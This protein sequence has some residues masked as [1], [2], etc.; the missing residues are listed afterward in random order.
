MAEIGFQ[1]R[2]HDT[3]LFVF[4]DLKLNSNLEV[5]DRLIGGIRT[6][7]PGANWIGAVH[8]NSKQSHG[9]DRATLGAA[10]RAGLVR[11][12][13]GLES[14]SQR[15]L[16]AMKK[17]TEL[18]VTSK[19]L[20]DAAE[21]RI[22]V[23][24]TMIHGYPGETTED[25]FATARFLEQHAGV[26]DRVMLNRFQVMIGPT[27]LRRYDATPEGVRAVSGL[28]RVPRLAIASHEYEP[29]RGFDYAR[30]TQRLLSAVTRIN[31]KPLNSGAAQFEGVM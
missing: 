29:A 2:R 30:A 19:F 9:L 1:S 8:V 21:A 17:G 31:R 22:S 20:H 16:D 7:A 27:F 10:R 18:S 13:T 14:G 5:W 25:V 12:T 3:S 23:R 6:H 24:V 4:T 15:L 28:K 26:I 11:L